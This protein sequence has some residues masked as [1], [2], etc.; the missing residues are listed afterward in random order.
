MSFPLFCP[1]QLSNLKVYETSKLPQNT[2]LCQPVWDVLVNLCCSKRTSP[3]QNYIKIYKSYKIFSHNVCKFLNVFRPFGLFTFVDA[4]ITMDPC[5]LFLFYFLDT[6]RLW[7]FS[8]KGS[9]LLRSV[10]VPLI[11]IEEQSSPNQGLIYQSSEIQ[12]KK[13]HIKIKGA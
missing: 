10:F 11:S 8:N 1:R 4:W 2:Y 5:W 13:N 7:W 3:W 12:Q 6:N 9:Y